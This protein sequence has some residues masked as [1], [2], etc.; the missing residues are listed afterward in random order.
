MDPRLTKAIAH[1]LRLQIL[2]AAKQGT[3]SPSEYSEETGAPLST[4]SYHFRKLADLGFLD[5]VEEIPK[6]GSREHR[7]RARRGVDAAAL[8]SREESVFYW[9]GGG[10]D[11]IGWR[12]FLEASRQLIHRVKDIEDA[13]AQRAAE[14]GKA[15]F[16]TTFAVAA[17]ESP[18]ATE[19]PKR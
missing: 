15:C 17:L 1:P 19:R 4:V 12:E 2:A 10:M 11:E 7:Y 6:R 13:S 5:L 14:G 9:A 3:I 18:V 8:D 16:P